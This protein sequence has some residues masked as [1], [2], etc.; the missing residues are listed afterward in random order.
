[1]PSSPANGASIRFLLMSVRCSCACAA[2]FRGRDEATLDEAAVADV[3]GAGL[4]KLRHEAGEP[5][6]IC[7]GVEFDEQ[8][9]R[10]Y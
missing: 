4:L 3:V 9:T 1:M 8:R 7:G 5:C 6:P 2:S 10:A